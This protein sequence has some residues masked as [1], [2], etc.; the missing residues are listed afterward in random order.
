MEK[1][2]HVQKRKVK[3]GYMKIRIVEYGDIVEIMLDGN[4]LQENVSYMKTRIIDLINDGKRKVILNMEGT[5]YI[6]SLCLAVLIDAKT[7]LTALQGD[8]K[9]AVVNR[10]VRNLM[11]ITNLVRKIEIFDTIEEAKASL[12]V[13]NS[14]P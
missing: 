4:V 12:G 8:L 13:S 9:I 6:S 5:E 3:R 2:F 14:E 7:R 11:E 1:S 10:L